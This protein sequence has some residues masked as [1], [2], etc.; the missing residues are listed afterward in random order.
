MPFEGLGYSVTK[1][2]FPAVMPI[3]HGGRLESGDLEESIPLHT[4]WPNLARPPSTGPE[5]L[6]G[7]LI[8]AR[9]GKYLHYQG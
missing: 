7:P 8:Y 6:K 9:S 2:T 3:D 5:G 4:F 1:E